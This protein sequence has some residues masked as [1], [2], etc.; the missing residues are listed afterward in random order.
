MSIGILGGTFDPVHNGH[1]D[2]ARAAQQALSLDE[3]WLMPCRVPPHRTAP[4][5]SAAHRF[6]MAALAASSFPH[7]LVS[8]LEMTS[9]APSY[10]VDTLDRLGRRG[11]DMSRV[12]VITG[13]DAFAGIASWRAFP[14]VLDRCHFA[15]VSRPGLP[16]LTLRDRL[17]DLASR[18]VTMPAAV[19]AQPAILLIDAPTAPIASTD[20]RARLAAGGR[21]SDLVPALVDAH[22]QKHHLYSADPAKGRA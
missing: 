16:A 14:A 6:A 20:V 15:V 8:D 2:L 10:T 11:A 21:A 18:M 7:M 22:I 12:F 4:H 9:D 17:P 13:A 5:A 1:L 3:L 19:T